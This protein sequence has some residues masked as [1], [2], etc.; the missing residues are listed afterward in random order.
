MDLVGPSQTE[1]LGGKNYVLVVV[2]D[3][4]RFTWVEFLHDKSETFELFK[5]LSKRLENEK[6][7][8]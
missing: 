4:S 7:K 3:F 6:Q 5:A 2:D 1:S 8:F